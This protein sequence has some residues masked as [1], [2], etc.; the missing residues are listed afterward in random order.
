MTGKAG[1]LDP[2]QTLPGSLSDFT[3]QGCE[4]VFAVHMSAAF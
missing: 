2:A 1:E 4:L 3:R